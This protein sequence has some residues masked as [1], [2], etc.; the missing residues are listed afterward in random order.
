MRIGINGAEALVGQAYAPL[1]VT[2]TDANYTAGVGQRLADVGTVIAL[3]K[4]PDSDLF[5][6]SFDQIGSMSHVRTDPVPPTPATP[7]D[8]PESSELGVRTFAE[9]NA[10][11]ATITG[12]SMNDANVKATYALVEQQLPTVPTIEGFVASHQVGVAQLAI[13][14]CNA[15]VESTQ[16]AAFFPG[17]NLALAPAAAFSPTNALIDPLLANGVGINMAL[18]TQPTDS[19]VRTELN[20][21]VGKLSSCNSGTGSVCTRTITKAACATVLGSAAV[22]LK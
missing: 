12:I 5:F 3:E 13:E 19:D 21:L 10:S 20:S 6:L 11:F 7:A 16:A 1:D 22:L 8:K 17:L 9:I 4:G 18:A 2:V 15:L 14:Y